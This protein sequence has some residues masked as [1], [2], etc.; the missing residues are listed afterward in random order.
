MS[1]IVRLRGNVGGGV[2]GVESIRIV[3]AHPMLALGAL[4]I[5]E[6]KFVVKIMR[7]LVHS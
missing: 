3:Q 5:L 2:R 7:H 6:V 1:Y 4:G